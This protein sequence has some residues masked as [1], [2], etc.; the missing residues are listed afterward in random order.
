MMKDIKS[1]SVEQPSQL[2]VRVDQVQDSNLLE[3]VDKL[4]QVGLV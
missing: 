1:G 4:S 3:T 2:G